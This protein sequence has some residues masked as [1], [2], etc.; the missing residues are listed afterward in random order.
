MAQMTGYDLLL[1]ELLGRKMVRVEGM[2]MRTNRERREQGT[3]PDIAI[4][5]IIIIIII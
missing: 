4:S 1:P 5:N 2:A 3:S